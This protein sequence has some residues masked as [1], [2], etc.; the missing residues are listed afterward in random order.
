MKSDNPFFANAIADGTLF[1]KDDYFILGSKYFSCGNSK[2]NYYN[3]PYTIAIA[4]IGKINK[5]DSR[6]NSDYHNGVA[7]ISNKLGVSKSEVKS[8]R[9]KYRCVSGYVFKTTYNI[10]I[11]LKCIIDELVKN[12]NNVIVAE[13]ILKYDAVNKMY[14]DL[15][16]DKQY[17]AIRYAA[18]NSSRNSVIHVSGELDHL[19][20]T[21]S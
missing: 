5:P 4:I 14:R 2:D 11:I 12:R 16:I 15:L 18:H 8:I 6:R 3:N 9:K 7:F 13:F 17:H 21:V 1:D 10:S 19:T 20:Q